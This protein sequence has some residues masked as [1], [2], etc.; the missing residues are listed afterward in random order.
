MSYEDEWEWWLEEAC[1][2]VSR[3]VSLL[4]IPSE[5]SREGWEKIDKERKCI[6]DGHGVV[7][8]RGEFI[9][10]DFGEAVEIF[11]ARYPWVKDLYEKSIQME[12]FSGHALVGLL[13]GYS[14]ESINSFF[15]KKTYVRS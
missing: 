1:Y 2:R 7:I 3:G 9:E 14:G 11:V 5:V 15:E 6:E 12:D 13:L 4:S 8:F 10:D